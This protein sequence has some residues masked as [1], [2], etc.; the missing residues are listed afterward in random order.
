M[1]ARALLETPG[2][3]GLMGRVLPALLLAGWI[4]AASAYEWAAWDWHPAREEPPAISAWHIGRAAVTGLLGAFF[5][6]SYARLRPVHGDALDRRFV[7]ASSLVLTLTLALTALLAFDPGAYHAIVEED[8]VVEWGSAL[9]LFVASIFAAK[10]LLALIRRT[11]RPALDLLAAGGFS[12]LFFVMAMEEISWFQRVIGFD[13]PGSVAER[14]WQGEF[15]LHNFQTDL[16][17]LALYSGTGLFLV[18]LPLLRESLASWA[19]FD[20]VV[21]LFPDRPVAAISAPMLMLTYG[22]FNLLA[23]QAATWIGAAVLVVFARDA[24]LARRPGETALYA[25]LAAGI[26]LGQA[27]YL[28]FG[29]A[30]I[31]I[32]DA[33]EYREAIIALGLALYAAR[34]W[35]GVR[36]AETR[37]RH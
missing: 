3:T 1:G 17:E 12:L 20:R 35:H 6:A 36:R 15:N 16:T 27:F 25:A 10:W 26:V 21:H 34:Q 5:L 22:Q 13:T 33:T 4:L 2:Q 28:A 32:F 30:M 23:V 18:L 8:G 14:N 31:E 11:Q 24:H 37:A 19:P 29:H 7:A 9:L